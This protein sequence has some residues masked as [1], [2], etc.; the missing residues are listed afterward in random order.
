[1]WASH[2]LPLT[3]GRHVPLREATAFGVGVLATLL[4][5]AF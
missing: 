5:R 4:I 1:M 3:R 2:D